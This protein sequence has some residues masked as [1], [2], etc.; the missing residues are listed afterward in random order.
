LKGVVELK[1]K[2]DF[3]LLV[4]DAHGF[5]TMGP[6]GAGTDEEQGVQ[7]G[8]DVYFGTFAKSMAGIGAFVAASEDVVDFLRY[9]MRSQ[10]F[11]KSLPMPMVIG[12]LKRL[13]LLRSNPELKNKLWTIVRALQSGLKERGFNIGITSSPVTPVFLEGSLMEATNIVMDLREN[14]GIFC[15]IVTYPVVPKGVIMLRLIPSAVHTL[16]DV[17]RTLSAYSEVAEKL[18]SGYYESK[19]AMPMN[20]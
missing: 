16:E 9:N 13:E 10:T 7:A 5:G 2:F 15:S 12:L 19:S 18:K 1:K 3:R 11:A 6:T 17:E 20:A 4:D 8:V 14:Y